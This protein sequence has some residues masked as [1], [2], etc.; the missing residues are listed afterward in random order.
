MDEL[1]KEV[2]SYLDEDALAS[3]LID[4]VNI[5]SPTGYEG[6]MGAYLAARL[7]DLGLQVKSQVVEED[8]E[9]VI[10]SWSGTGDGVD[11]MFLGHLDTAPGIAEPV[12]RVVDGWITG[13]GAANMKAAFPCYL[14]AV[15]M[16]QRAGAEINGDI[17]IAGVCG[18]IERA[19]IGDHQG[20]AFRGGGFGARYMA[21][22]GVLADVVINGEPTGRR[23]QVANCGYAFLRLT[24]RGVSQHTAYREQGVDAI[25]K[26]ITVIDAVNAWESWYQDHHRHSSITP[27]VGIGAI[28][29][30][31]PPT[32][33]RSPAD[34]C[35]LYV[36]VTLLPDS[37]IQQVLRDFKA[38]LATLKR[39]DPE[40]DVEVEAYMTSKGYEISPDAFV[41]QAMRRA[42]TLVNDSEPNEVD[43]F[44]CNVSSDNS[45]LFEY[46]V[47]GITYGPAGLSRT[48]SDI[49]AS[50]DE[51]YGEAVSIK[52]L[53]RCTQAYALAALEIAT[54]SREEIGDG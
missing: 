30:G 43:R 13:K 8:R 54:Q 31:Y 50:Y 49:Y 5:D 47:L 25:A 45:P 24:T 40:L 1:K 21:S 3:M 9:N 27:R 53:V 18:E 19:P 34:F 28:E 46:G 39:N 42:H 7:S 32:P 37:S 20:R 51:E 36:D 35:H 48:H 29:G 17:T 10:G 26:M 11:L 52:D 12:G 4:M 2:L 14:M 23:V 22:H 16:L 38:M 6:E 15:N 41:A 33:A 44:R